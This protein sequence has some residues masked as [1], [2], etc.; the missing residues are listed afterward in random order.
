MAEVPR[1][2]TIPAKSEVAKKSQPK[3]ITSF[4]KRRSSEVTD[5]ANQENKRS[6]VS[7]ED[8]EHEHQNQPTDHPTETQRPIN[9]EVDPKSIERDPGKRQ[10]IWKYPANQKE[11]VRRDYLNFGPFQVH[12]KEYPGKVMKKHTRR[13][14]YSWF[15]IFPNWLE[16]SPTTDSAYCFICYLF[17]DK[18]NVQKGVDA[19][20]VKGFNNWKKVNDGNNCAFLKHMGSS[21]HKDAVVKS[22]NLLNHKAH[23]ENV[24]EKR[25]AEDLLKNRIRLKASVDV[26]RWLTFQAC[27]FRGNDETVGSKNRG[28][29]IELL[30]LLASYNDEVEKVVLQNA[31]FNSRYTSG[32]IQK[33]ILSI[34]ASKVQ[35]HI[36]NEVGDS[37]FC[38]MVDE[39]R[40][41]AKQEQMAIVI[42]F[43]DKDGIIRERFLD[44]VH[45]TDTSAMT[46]KTNLWNILL[47][48][49]FDTS[50]IRGQGYDGASNMRGE[51]N[52]LQ[53]LVIK[54]CPYAY[55]VHCF[56]HRLQLALVAA[57]REVIPVHQFFNKLSCIINV[58]C[59]SSKCHDELQKSKAL[60]IKHLLELGET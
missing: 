32:E 24:I 56:A 14:Q 60:E 43:V 7:V 49:E 3:K 48:Y 5:D 51:W 39:A 26:I 9:V 46:L 59:A 2:Q 13:F 31:P 16:Y 54:E 55:Y 23:I 52:G 34:I 42:R 57:S 11:Q 45:V 27:A 6:K 20:T 8:Q 21:Q 1:N 44:L 22:E 38:V 50:K 47:Q 58:I 53:A 15:S 29:F 18:P 28:N 37:Y 25:N 33:E 10:P 4:F 36:R 40:D 41:E 12:L 35:K 30:K 17:S 19:F